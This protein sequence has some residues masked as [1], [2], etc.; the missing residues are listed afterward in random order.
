MTDGPKPPDA[1]PANNQTPAPSAHGS[2]AEAHDAL[3]DSA[4][5]PFMAHLIE[6]RQR[7][8]KGLFAVVALFLPIYFFANDLYVLVAAPLMAH[9]PGDSTM[10]A[11]EVA[12]PFLTPFKLAIYAAIFVGMPVILHQ[13]WSFVAPGLY[14]H[15]KRFAMP[16]LLSSIGLFY[17]GMAFAYFAVFPLVFQFMAAVT[18]IGVTMMTDINRYLDFVLT[19]FL[20]FGFAFEIPIATLLLVW[21]GISTAQGIANKRPYVIVGCFAAGMLLT[22]PD[23]ISQLLLALPTWVLFEIGILFARVAEKRNEVA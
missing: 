20:A 11:T 17:L 3:V 4:E 21:S 14:K 1:E 7:I 6:L 8:L 5:M 10:I 13:A 12:S 15:E 23:V 22:P 19:M 9:L 2:D 18:P 16:L